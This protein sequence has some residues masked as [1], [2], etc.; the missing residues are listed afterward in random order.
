METGS[1]IDEV[2]LARRTMVLFFLIDTS[3][4]MQGEKIL[5]VNH[6]IGEI[7][8]E[9]RKISAENADAQ[10]KIAVMSFSSGTEW[11]TKNGPEE[12]DT[13]VWRSLTA[14]GVTDMGEAC[15]Q[16]AKKL[17][18]Q[19]GGFMK[20]ATGSYAPVIFMISDGEP[21][22]DFDAGLKVLKENNWYKAAIKI[23]LAIG[24]GANTEVLAR[25]VG[26]PEGVI[27]VHDPETLKK[28]IRFCSVTAS[29]VA[30]KSSTA[31]S[32][33][34]GTPGEDS[35]KKKDVYDAIG[36][37]L[38][39]SGNVIKAPDGTIDTAPPAGKPKVW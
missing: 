37:E 28:L 29:K 30:S 33:A 38:A 36:A 32:N 10:I 16:L 12:A 3:G 22:D 24:D 7:V 8:P 26:S 39:A 25:F 2:E 9:I 17:S 27:T 35:G 6:A 4:S 14:A 13:Y 15:R 1:L 5:A 31:K 23:A 34:D 19:S 11:L 20:E 21:V 18:T